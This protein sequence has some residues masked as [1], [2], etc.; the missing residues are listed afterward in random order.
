MSRHITGSQFKDSN[1][2]Q[3]PVTSGIL[4]EEEGYSMW[5]RVQVVEFS[6]GWRKKTKCAF[7]ADLI[8]T[9]V[10]ESLFRRKCVCVSNKHS[11]TTWVA[12][13]LKSVMRRE[14]VG[15][16]LHLK[17]FI[18]DN[19]FF[20]CHCDVVSLISRPCCCSCALRSA[21]SFFRSSIC[22]TI[23]IQHITICPIRVGQQTTT[24]LINLIICVLNLT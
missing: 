23:D 11:Y 6:R 17:L 12:E 18:R 14:Q 15:L 1:Q 24:D 20:F 9:T 7:T 5:I 22:R 10:R 21:L 13:H 16:F 19:D 8:F 4:L 3:R 2:R